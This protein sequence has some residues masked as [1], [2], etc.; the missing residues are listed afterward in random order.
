MGSDW[1]VDLAG[2][3]A[4][5]PWQGLEL[6]MV[7]VAVVFWIYW[8]IAQIRQENADYADDVQRHGTPEAIRRA[9]DEHP[10]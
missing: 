9:L 10:T 1:A 6:I 7:V 4:V 8:H 2:V 5:Y 3:G